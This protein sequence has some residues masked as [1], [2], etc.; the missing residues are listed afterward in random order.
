MTYDQYKELI[1]FACWYKKNKKDPRFRRLLKVA[2]KDWKALVHINNKAK[3]KGL[4]DHIAKCEAEAGKLKSK[5]LK[6]PASIA[7]EY[8][9]LWTTCATKFRKT[10]NVIQKAVDGDQ[11]HDFE[12]KLAAAQADVENFEQDMKKYR[13]LWRSYEKK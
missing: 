12:G 4:G 8:C 2:I 11:L 1:P 5:N 13:S 9:T 7:S 6:M 10:K 3:V